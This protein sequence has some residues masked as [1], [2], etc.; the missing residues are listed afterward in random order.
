MEPL[1]ANKTVIYLLYNKELEKK[2]LHPFERRR[3]KHTGDACV[4]KKMQ[5]E[6]IS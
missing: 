3:K 4:I 1:H 5:N 6:H 2:A